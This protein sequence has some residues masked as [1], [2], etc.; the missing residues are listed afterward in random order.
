M[1]KVER[2]AQIEKISSQFACFK[3]DY[4]G[5]PIRRALLALK[6]GKCDE[7]LSV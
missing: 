7:S 6:A 1:I 5:A 4:I 2:D 3:R